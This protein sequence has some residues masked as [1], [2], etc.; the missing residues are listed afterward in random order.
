VTEDPKKD[1]DPK[2]LT[3]PQRAAASLLVVVLGVI[4]APIGLVMKLFASF[5]R[6]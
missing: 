4:F 5:R 6:R 2:E 1:T 3:L